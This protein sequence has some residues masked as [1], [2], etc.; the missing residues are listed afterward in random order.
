MVENDVQQ[1][2]FLKGKAFLAFIKLYFCNL[3]STIIGP[4]FHSLTK[5]QN[6]VVN[7][8]K[9]NKLFTAR[10]FS[11][12]S[13][14]SSKLRKSSKI[15]WG[16]KINW[17]KSQHTRKVHWNYSK[18][19]WGCVDVCWTNDKLFSHLL[20]IIVHL[21]HYV[22][23]KN[24]CCI[25]DLLLDFCANWFTLPF[26]LIL[27]QGSSC[28]LVGSLVQLFNFWLKISKLSNFYHIFSKPVIY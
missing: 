10:V 26:I 9:P 17:N 25:Y 1:Y 13:F 6:L 11:Q 2:I 14:P 21:V 4:H 7:V 8:P 16:S 28:G 18:V 3:L 5:Y 19:I 22:G 20:H 24:I 23:H 12:F 27:L 15:N